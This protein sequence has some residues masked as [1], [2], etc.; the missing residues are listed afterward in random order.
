MRNMT[1][2]KSIL[3]GFV[4]SSGLFLSA[5][6][7]AHGHWH[8]RHYCIQ[9]SSTVVSNTVTSKGACQA[10]ESLALAEKW[11]SYPLLRENSYYVEYWQGSFSRQ[12]TS[13]LVTHH[14]ILDICESKT[15]L[16]E[17]TNQ[18]VT[19]EKIFAVENPNLAD[20]ISTSYELVPMTDA[21]AQAVLSAAQLRCAQF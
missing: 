9:E 13:T 21:E 19:E 2:K 5:N 16:D 7:M 14:Q 12:V 10:K 1:F 20:T 8:H 18:V 17:T 15:L 11:Q 6:A 3:F 4:L